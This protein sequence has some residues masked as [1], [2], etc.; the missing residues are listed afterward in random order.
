MIQKMTFSTNPPTPPKIL[1][2]CKLNSLIL[3]A[4]LYKKNSRRDVSFLI[5]SQ[6]HTKEEMA[7]LE[8]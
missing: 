6:L 2:R 7:N 8:D 3:N 4:L 1:F 5:G